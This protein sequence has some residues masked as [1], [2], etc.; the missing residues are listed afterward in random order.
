MFNS[1]IFSNYEKTDEIISLR[2]EI[3]SNLKGMISLI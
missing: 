3:F 2:D 1:I